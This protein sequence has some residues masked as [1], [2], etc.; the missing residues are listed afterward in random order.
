MNKDR[1]DTFGEGE[2][3]ASSTE[4]TGLMPA[5]P[6]NMEEDRDMAEM[7]RIHSAKKDG[8]KRRTR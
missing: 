8:K 4:C 6:Q 5:L 3:I 7:Y 2:T 1:Q